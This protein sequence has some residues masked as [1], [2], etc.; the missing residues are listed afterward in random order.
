[1]A[2]LDSLRSQQEA[3]S[4]AILDKL[5]I[6]DELKKVQDEK[7][8][9]ELGIDFTESNEDLDV[10]QKSE[11]L[12]VGKLK[13][14]GSTTTQVDVVCEPLMED[15][16]GY[17]EKGPR[18]ILIYAKISARTLV[19]PFYGV[20]QRHNRRWAV[21]KDL[22]KCLT[23]ADAIKTS[24]MPASILDRIALAHQIATTVDYLHSVEVLIK[25][26]SDKTVLLSHNGDA[27]TPYLTELE[28][29]RLV[30]EVTACA[31]RQ[32]S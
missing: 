13:L 32:G 2:K 15:V 4:S 14:P 17:G 31:M 16:M 8:A 26:L 28:K 7:A 23:L 25:R 27:I 5:S 20:A 9:G 3:N 10:R 1:L 6:L 12:L 21:M 30:G 11:D 29:A 24:Q 18:H 22:R 19:H